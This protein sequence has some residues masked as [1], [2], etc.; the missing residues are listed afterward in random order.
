VSR[1]D[2]GARDGE[3]HIENDALAVH[4][5]NHADRGDV[6]CE[7]G[8][9]THGGDIV[10]ADQLAEEDEGLFQDLGEDVNEGERTGHNRA[11]VDDGPHTLVIEGSH[12]GQERNA[13]QLGEKSDCQTERDEDLHALAE[14]GEDLDAAVGRERKTRG[15]DAGEDDEGNEVRREVGE[16]HFQNDAGDEAAHGDRDDAAEHTE[17]DVLMVLLVDDAERERDREGNRCAEHGGNDEAVEVAGDLASR[18]LYGK[19]RAAHIVR[20]QGT[21]DDGRFQM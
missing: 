7:A 14:D 16:A 6:G 10:D 20:K 3:R 12:T 5:L 21:H 11:G 18:N 1:E 8:D 13:R 9:Q 15:D 17:R 4:L 19:G 2:E